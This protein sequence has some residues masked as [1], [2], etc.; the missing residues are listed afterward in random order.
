[1]IMSRPSDYFKH[2]GGELQSE[3]V[4]LSKIAEK[5]GTPVYVYSADA[6]RAPLRALKQGLGG[7]DHLVCFAMKSNSNI[8]VLKLLSDEGAGMDLVSGGEPLSRP[9]RRSALFPNCV[10]GRRQVVRA[11]KFGKRSLGTFSL[12]M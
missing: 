4:A 7:I 8:A 9:A 2:V 10:L 5:V 1:M 12:S 3:G 6:L 11:K